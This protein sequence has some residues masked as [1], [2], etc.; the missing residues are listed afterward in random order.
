MTL[1]PTAYLIEPHLTR[2]SNGRAPSRCWSPTAAPPRICGS[3]CLRGVGAKDRTAALPGSSCGPAGV[4]ASGARSAR[5]RTATRSPT[6][7][8]ARRASPPRWLAAGAQRPPATRRTGRIRPPSSSASV[9]VG[10]RSGWGVPPTASRRPVPRCWPVP[11]PQA[12][13]TPA[14]TP[15][16]ASNGR[17]DL[18]HRPVERRVRCGCS[19]VTGLE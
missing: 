17:H 10:K 6:P 13:R 7:L 12:I 4:R 3:A 15:P 14:P 18:R 16:A 11:P 1:G 9:R 5:V 19:G 2:P 8:P